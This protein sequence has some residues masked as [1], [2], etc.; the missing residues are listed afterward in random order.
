MEECQKWERVKLIIEDIMKDQ[1]VVKEGRKSKEKCRKE[2][3]EM[4]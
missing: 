4:G 3:G 2:R 1:E